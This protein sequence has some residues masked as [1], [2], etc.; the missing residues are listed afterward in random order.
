MST[1]ITPLS[2]T[3]IAKLHRLST[4]ITTAEIVNEIA[5]ELVDATNT[6]DLG[7]FDYCRIGDLKKSLNK[8]DKIVQT[9]WDAELLVTDD[10]EVHVLALAVHRARELSVAI[11][12][13][14]ATQ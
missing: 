2:K 8:L 13:A 11:R 6:L 1:T 9:A 5:E 12:E 3:D 14:L 7:T 10:I 4:T